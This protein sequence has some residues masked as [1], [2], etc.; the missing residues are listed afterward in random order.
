[1]LKITYRENA[2]LKKKVEKKW[3][4][5]VFYTTNVTTFVHFVKILTKNENQK[6]EMRLF[7]QFFYTRILGLF[8]RKKKKKT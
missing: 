8:F 6:H 3:E 4:K 2:E 1:M 5:N 7:F